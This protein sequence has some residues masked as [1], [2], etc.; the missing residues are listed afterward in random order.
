VEEIKIKPI[1]LK[2]FVIFN[3]LLVPSFFFALH[4]IEAFSRVA[5]IGNI[6]VSGDIRPDRLAGGLRASFYYEGEKFTETESESDNVS[7][8]QFISNAGKLKEKLKSCELLYSSRL[9]IKL[10]FKFNTLK[11]HKSLWSLIKC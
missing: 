9:F 1:F 5:P 8:I 10:Q 4:P 2:L 3:L 6:N 11:E 7:P